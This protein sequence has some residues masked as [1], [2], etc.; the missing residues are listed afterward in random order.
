MLRAALLCFGGLMLVKMV[1]F[2]KIWHYGFGLAAIGTILLV[3]ELTYVLPRW[4]DRRGGRGSVFALAFG[5]L[6]IAILA[7]H[8]VVTASASQKKTVVVCEGLELRTY[9]QY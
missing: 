5:L 3:T 2:V 9:G 1:L 8:C 6:W 7:Q 4:I